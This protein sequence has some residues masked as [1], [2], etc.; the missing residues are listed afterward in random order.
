MHLAHFYRAPSHV[1][2]T[3]V[4]DSCAVRLEREAVLKQRTLQSSHGAG[5][6]IS[7]HAQE[8]A[9][10]D[11]PQMIA[12][13]APLY[14]QDNRGPVRFTV[15]CQR[16][17]RHLLAELEFSSRWTGFQ[18]MHFSSCHLTLHYFGLV[19]KSKVSHSNQRLASICHKYIWVVSSSSREACFSQ[20]LLLRAIGPCPA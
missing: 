6:R 1:T 20:P 16:S 7:L 11:A 12:L 17:Q 3:P 14:Q 2:I 10:P 15:I 9:K 13:I 18:P 8:L 4:G 5:R 19:L